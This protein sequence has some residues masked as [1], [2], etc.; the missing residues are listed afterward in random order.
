MVHA[1][2]AAVQ[3]ATWSWPRSNILRLGTMLGISPW[4]QAQ[5][6]RTSM[7]VS[8]PTHA[9]VQMHTARDCCSLTHSPSIITQSELLEPQGE[10]TPPRH[11]PAALTHIRNHAP[12]RQAREDQAQ[13]AQTS[14]YGLS[15]SHILIHTLTSTRVGAQGTSHCGCTSV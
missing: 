8:P 3:H 9:C 10:I 2:V 11:A 13:G 4:K 14:R 5:S 7:H 1:V 15:F 6:N 12:V